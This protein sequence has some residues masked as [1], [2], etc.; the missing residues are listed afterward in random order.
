MVT[1]LEKQAEEIKAHGATTSTTSAE[2]NSVGDRLIAISDETKAYDTRLKELEAKLQRQ[3]G[4][5]GAGSYIECSAGAQF[6]TSAEYAN[7]KGKATDTFEFKSFHKPERKDVTNL[8]NSAGDLIR[9]MRQPPIVE[10]TGRRIDHIRQ[11]MNV[12]PTSEGVVE[13]V[14]ETFTNN[15]AAQTAELAEK[16]ESEIA[17]DLKSV[18]MSTI[19]HFVTASRQVLSDA[20]MLMNRIDNA[21]TWG[22]YAKEDTYLLYGTGLNGQP[23]GLMV[24]SSV[25]NLGA[26]PATSTQ[27]DHIRRAIAMARVAEYPVTSMVIHP[28]NWADLELLKDTTDR[29]IWVSVNDGGIPRVWRV[30]VVETTA[31]DEDDFLVGNFQLGA[32]MWDREQA[33]IRVAEQHGELFIKNGVVILG[34]ERIALSIERPQSFVKGTFAQ[35]S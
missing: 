19:A 22:I 20:G 34:E 2:I 25:Q 24:N 3:A 35:V 18:S 26:Q 4:A 11:I 15:A 23:E 17:F 33:S 10:S 28:N 29:Y 13:Y 30:P 32:T 1:L 8:S 27:L 9:A 12:V 21:L 14:V 5:G 16:A 6:I 7:R 31:I